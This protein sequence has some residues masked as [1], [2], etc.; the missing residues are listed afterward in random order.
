MYYRWWFST[1]W[2]YFVFS[3]KKKMIAA[4]IKANSGISGSD[5]LIYFFWWWVVECKTYFYGSVPYNVSLRNKK[6]CEILR[7]FLVWKFCND[8]LILES[9]GQWP[10][11]IQTHSNVEQFTDQEV[12]IN[13]KGF[14]CGW[15][16]S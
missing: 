13:S 2:K 3:K 14:C 11:H 6:H 10:L 7:N 16:F 8:G 9:H 5:C 4:H 12:A 1:I 15:T